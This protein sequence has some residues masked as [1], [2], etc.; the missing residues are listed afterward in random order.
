MSP[1]VPL[2]SIGLP[3]RNAEDRVAATIRTVLDQDHEDLELVISD[4]A[5]TDGTEEVCRDAA[6]S[7]PRVRYHRQPVDLGILGNFQTTMRLAGGR[8]F[9]WIGDDD[10]IHPTYV[11]RCLEVFDQRPETLLVTTQIEYVAPDGSSETTTDYDP[12][13]LA[14]P[15]PVTRLE[16]ILRYLN[17][18]AVLVDPLYSMMRRDRVLAI[19]RVNTL[20]EDEVF[21]TRLA[22]AAP[23]G[24]VPALLAQRHTRAGDLRDIARRLGVPAWQLRV[25]TALVARTVLADIATGDL[26][27]ADRRRARSAVARFYVTRHQRTVRHRSRRVAEMVAGTVP[28]RGQGTVAT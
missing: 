24:H 11:S 9:R 5:S 21:A 19:P 22:L 13:P 15:D 6:R 26:G 2:V 16:G 12:G 4:N 25:T 23:W 27:P 18:S 1:P 14:D 10:A 3:V 17:D 8:L 28:H 20:R 7:D